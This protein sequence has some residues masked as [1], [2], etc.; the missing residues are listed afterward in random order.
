MIEEFS[1]EPSLRFL[2][3]QEFGVEKLKSYYASCRYEI[4]EYSLG[5]KLMWETAAG[6]QF[7]EAGNC[8]ICMQNA[9]GQVYF[10]YPV[11]GENGDV[12]QALAEIE[13]YKADGGHFALCT[14]RTLSSALLIAKDLGLTG[15]LAC[16]QG[17]V[18]K[19]LFATHLNLLEKKKRALPVSVKVTPL[20]TQWFSGIKSLRK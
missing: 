10:D 4:C 18:A 9:D 13:R 19:E 11:L 1:K 2:P 16:F 6:Y 12:E 15:L 3:A 8:L 14:G 20:T 17:S 7:A 5:V